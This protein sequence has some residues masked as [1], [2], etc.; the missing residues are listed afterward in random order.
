V[1]R[2]EDFKALI[3]KAQ[4][5]V[6]RIDAAGAIGFT[7]PCMVRMLGYDSEG[8]LVGRSILYIIKKS[9]RNGVIEKFLSRERGA[10]DS[11]FV[12]LS[13]KDGSTFTARFSSVPM[14]EGD[15]FA[16]SCMVVIDVT[17]EARLFDRLKL[18]EARFRNLSRHL[19]AAIFELD[20][21]SNI[22][23]CNDF[24]HDLLGIDGPGCQRSLRSFVAADELARYDRLMTEAFGG[25][26]RGAVPLDL[27]RKG[28]ERLPALWSV[29]LERW[30]DGSP[31][32]SVVV[33]EVAS[34]LASIF[35]FNE[36]VFSS[37]GLTSRELAVAKSLASGLIYK[38]IAYEL[39]ISLST[40][41][42]H[43]MSL[44]RKIGIHSREELVDLA[45]S[46]QVER[47][48]KNSIIQK[49]IHKKILNTLAR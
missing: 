49:L 8:E 22:R 44:Y 24:A 20:A 9:E 10:S 21:D 33:I 4:V 19:P 46:W 31:L 43:T 18:S 14:G 2:D 12:S 16:G 7:N 6:I 45:N 15:L 5:G 35:S 1:H 25:R 38:E 29:A 41:R 40:V 23:Y 39:G 27:V 17:R 48:G 3:M 13:R 36:S 47:Y 32:A 37:Y 34:V 42:T 26:D 28:C 30:R 11:Y